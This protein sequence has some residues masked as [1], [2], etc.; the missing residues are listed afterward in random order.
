MPQRRDIHL[1]LSASAILNIILIKILCSLF[2]LFY[3]RLTD[4]F[5]W[6]SRKIKIQFFPC[7]E[8]FS[9]SLL[10]TKNPNSLT[11]HPWQTWSLWLLRSLL[12]PPYLPEEFLCHPQGAYRCLDHT[13]PL[14]EMPTPFPPPG[15]GI[16]SIR[17][18]S[19]SW[20]LK[21]K[22]SLWSPTSTIVWGSVILTCRDNFS[23]IAQCK[24]L[25]SREPTP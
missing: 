17:I 2:V 14:F 8:A 4:Q 11:F 24:Y 21:D 15:S 9:G 16:T 3:M 19:R 22:R 20:G 1:P 10:S 23:P 6:Y 7:S 12:C 25:E 13:S 18:S 5:P